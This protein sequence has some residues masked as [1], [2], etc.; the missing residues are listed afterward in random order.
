MMKEGIVSLKKLLPLSPVHTKPTVGRR[1]VLVSRT[2]TL[3]SVCS[4]LSAEVGLS[5]V[6]F[7][8]RFGMLNYHGSSSVGRAI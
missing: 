8:G 2:T 1:V 6:C 4:A 5:S 7:F 3:F